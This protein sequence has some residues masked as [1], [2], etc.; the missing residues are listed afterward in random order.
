[1]LKTFRDGSRKTEAP[2]DQQYRKKEEKGQKL[3]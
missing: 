1:M 3:A 2:G